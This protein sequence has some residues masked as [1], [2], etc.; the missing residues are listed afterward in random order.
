MLAEVDRR[1][2]PGEAAAHD[3][4]C[5]LLDHRVPGEAGLDE[6]V[7]VEV[8]ELVGQLTPLGHTLRAQ[9]LLLL[10]PVPLAQLVDR[11]A[12]CVV[13]LLHCCRPSPVNRTCR[14]VQC[15]DG[16][17][18]DTLRVRST[19]R[20]RGVCRRSHGP[21][22]RVRPGC[23][24]IRPLYRPFRQSSTRRE[25]GSSRSEPPSARS[26]GLLDLTGLPPL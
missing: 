24:L 6:R 19:S 13:V 20:S 17:D 22:G 15:R 8:L 26:L 3:H 10:Q 4:D 7:P 5:G 2:H 18:P 16:H 14:V 9:A 21:A 11:G 25:P 1:E 23:R 12:L